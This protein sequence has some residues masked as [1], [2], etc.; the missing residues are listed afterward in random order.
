MNSI[1]LPSF[2]KLYYELPQNIRKQAIKNYHLWREHPELPG[3]QFKLVG[4]KLPVYSVRVN[5]NYR[6]L[7]I[8]KDDTMNWFWIGKHD[9]YDR[10]LD[11]L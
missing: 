7:G 9:E 11:N 4:K 1:G 6:A 5:D 2:W 3:L 8:L 10:I